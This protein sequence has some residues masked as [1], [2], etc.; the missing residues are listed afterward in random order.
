MFDYIFNLKGFIDETISSIYE[1]ENLPTEIKDSWGE[2]SF[3]VNIEH[4]HD[5]VVAY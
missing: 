5:E 4:L 3:V 2:L 1:N